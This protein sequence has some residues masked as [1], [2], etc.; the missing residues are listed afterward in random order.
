MQIAQ[1]PELVGG[2]RDGGFTPEEIVQVQ[3]AVDALYGRPAKVGDV[4]PLYIGANGR[5]VGYWVTRMDGTDATVQL[6]W[7]PDKSGIKPIP[8]LTYRFVYDDTWWA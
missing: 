1:I 2:L 8:Y 5:T 6:C 4:N 7:M 3:K